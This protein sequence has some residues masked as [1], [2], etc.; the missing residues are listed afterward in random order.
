MSVRDD[1]ADLA[2]A[3]LAAADIEV[4]VVRSLRDPGILQIPI[5]VIDQQTVGRFAPAPLEHST[6]GMILHLVSRHVD[7]DDAEDELD[8][9]LPLVLDAFD[10]QGQIAWVTATK[11][12]YAGKYTA[13]DIEFQIIS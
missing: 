13:Y 10:Q 11:V 4:N 8:E 3:A 1:V 6:V 7:M 9:L 12:P 5:L 2:V